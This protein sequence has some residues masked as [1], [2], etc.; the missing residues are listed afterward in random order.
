VEQL[1]NG[2]ITIAPNIPT[3]PNGD[4][5]LATVK[6]NEVILN[7]DQQ[8]RAGGPEF[9]R[10][11]GVPGFGD[12][13]RVMDIRAFASGG[14]TGIGDRELGSNLKAPENPQSYLNPRNVNNPEMKKVMDAINQQTENIN[15]LV[16]QTNQRID[17]LQVILNPLSVGKEINKNK[18]A[19]SLGR[20]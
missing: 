15:L 19:T 3:Q 4:N 12:G 17:K 7:E 1:G 16:S 13:G 8:R 11:L 6:T 14:Y 9:F 5:V 2:R 18:K 10:R 20:V